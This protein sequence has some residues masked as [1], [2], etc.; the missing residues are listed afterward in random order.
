ME[1]G[2]CVAPPRSELIHR[3]LPSLL[4]L[5]SNLQGKVNQRWNSDYDRRQLAER[6][7]HFPVHTLGTITVLT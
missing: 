5:R 6:G 4:G 7:Q 3:G 2:H 1:S